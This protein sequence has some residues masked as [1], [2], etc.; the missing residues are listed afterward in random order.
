MTFRIICSG[1]K[2]PLYSGFDLKSSRDILKLTG[3]ICKSCGTNLSPYDFNI[4][5]EGNIN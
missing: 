4:D 5:I 2:S 3:G 1:C